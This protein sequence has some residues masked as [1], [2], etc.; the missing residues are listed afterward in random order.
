MTN[1]YIIN[2]SLAELTLGWISSF[3]GLHLFELQPKNTGR[4]LYGLPDFQ[5][6]GFPLT[7]QWCKHHSLPRTRLNAT[8]RF[9]R[10]CF[11][12]WKQTK[13]TFDKNP[14]NRNK[15]RKTPTSF[16]GLMLFCFLI[17]WLC[18]CS[19]VMLPWWSMYLKRSGIW[20]WEGSGDKD[21]HLHFLN[22]NDGLKCRRRWAPGEAPPSQLPPPQA[23]CI[24]S[25]LGASCPWVGGDGFPP[26]LLLQH[27]ETT[28]GG[29]EETWGV[30][31]WRCGGVRG[32]SQRLS[33][34]GGQFQRSQR[35]M[36][37]V[38]LRSPR[39]RV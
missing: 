31:N 10:S 11:F 19:V 2:D 26:P 24:S 3:S 33:L 37:S 27:N 1:T 14:P 9:T 22:I 8:P 17:C 4:M 13:P 16:C 12:R 21:P 36:A 32:K 30:T 34:H 6:K 29:W 20:T 15:V 7:G 39:I 5:N 28:V 23:A 38:H 35:R 18:E 25:H